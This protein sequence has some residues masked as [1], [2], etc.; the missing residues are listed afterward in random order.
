MKILIAFDKFKN[1]L[2]ATD[3]GELAAEVLGEQHSGWEVCLC[4]MS[5][6][7][8]G[9]GQILTQS[10]AGDWEEA[11]VRGPRGGRSFGRLRYRLGA[12]D[13]SGSAGDVPSVFAG[14]CPCG[15]CRN[16]DG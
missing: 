7:G 14:R 5:D 16:G 2:T 15:D 4:P 8:E 11:W 13:S 6:G 1:S 3:A 9:F 12:I 10:V